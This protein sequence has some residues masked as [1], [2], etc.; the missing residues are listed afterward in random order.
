MRVNLFRREGV[1]LDRV[2]PFSLPTLSVFLSLEDGLT[3]LCLHWV[4]LSV[5]S[6]FP[7]LRYISI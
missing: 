6:C 3:L 1:E 5:L 4:F 2:F 7:T